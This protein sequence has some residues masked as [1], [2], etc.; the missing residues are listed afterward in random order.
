M[1]QVLA[2]TEHGN[3][4]FGE[5]EVSR[6]AIFS[7]HFKVVVVQYQTVDGDGRVVSK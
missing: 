7:R 5:G 2:A 3:D 1:R 4:G 6:L